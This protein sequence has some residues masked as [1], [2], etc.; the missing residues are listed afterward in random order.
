MIDSVDPRCRPIRREREGS[1][2]DS[3][4]DERRAQYHFGPH[5]V[6]TALPP[7]IAAAS[8]HGRFE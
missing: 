1:E 5:Q 4:R 3:N 2:P 8:R 7:M 6:D